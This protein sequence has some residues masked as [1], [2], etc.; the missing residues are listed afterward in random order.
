VC[1]GRDFTGFHNCHL[2]CQYGLMG[3]VRA[4]PRV[5]VLNP[6]RFDGLPFMKNQ[7]LNHSE[8]NRFSNVRCPRFPLSHD[9]SR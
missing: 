1:S 2:M 7:M 6:G 4:R 5:K 3:I 9:L 8:V